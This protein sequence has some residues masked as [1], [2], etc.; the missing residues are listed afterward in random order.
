MSRTIELFGLSAPCVLP[1]T[2]TST[3]D[4]GKCLEHV[5]WMLSSG[6]GSVTL[7][8][9]TGEGSSIGASDRQAIIRALSDGGIELRKAI[10]GAVIGTSVSDAVD[11]CRLLLEAECKALLIAPPFYFKKVDD[12]GLFAWFAQLFEKLGG[13]ARDVLLYN[14]P[15]VTAVALSL[16]L[17]GRL[18][19]AYPEVVTGVLDA[20]GNWSNTTRLLS[21][22]R[23]SVILVGDDTRLGEGIR[24]GAQG[25]ISGFGNICP[26]ICLDVIESG[27]DDRRIA[28]MV[29]EMA[30]YPS[31]QA[32]KALVARRTAD[33][34]WLN[35]LP[36][37][38]PLSR[39]DAGAV[40]DSCA[41]ILAS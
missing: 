39:G 23:D 31:L 2:H 13:L 1:I 18:R 21:E 30:K 19:N 3:V 32:I 41:A 12:D 26:R 4:L 27:G 34:A 33:A 40:A 20:S 8:G 7:F 25:T 22:H 36:P 28:A 10:V 29:G 17:I 14:I 5:K 16:D 24:L 15:S 35:V 38:S 9:T 11:Q 37:L 6:C